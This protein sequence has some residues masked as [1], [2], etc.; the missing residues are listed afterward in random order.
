MTVAALFVL[1]VIV[2]LLPFMS[3]SKTHKPVDPVSVSVAEEVTSQPQE[4][5]VSQPLVDDTHG[6]I[7]NSPVPAEVS[8]ASVVIT[9]QTGTFGFE[10][11]QK[12]HSQT[13]SI[14]SEV[15]L[16]ELVDAQKGRV[17]GRK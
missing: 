1:I 4:Q 3:R 15:Q 6:V 10:S 9:G 8:D 17:T 11:T 16:R 13:S 14:L 7:T 2:A 5:V 12:S